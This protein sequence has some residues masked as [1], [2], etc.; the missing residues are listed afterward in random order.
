RVIAAE[1]RSPKKCIVLDAD[2]TL[3][4]GIIGEDGIEG[5]ALGEDFPGSAFRAFQK[6][7]LYIK[8]KGVLLAIASKNNEKD[9]FEVL[10]KHDAMV[11]RRADIAVFQVHWD[12][13]V[14]SLR[15]IAETLNIGTDTL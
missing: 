9:F 10:D 12:S 1:T 3:W 4:G 7:L 15:R 14:D 11:L 8:K 2:N 5:I 13:K 6:H